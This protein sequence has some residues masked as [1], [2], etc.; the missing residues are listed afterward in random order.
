[1]FKSA[2]FYDF[3][4]AA[5]MSN[6]TFVLEDPAESDSRPRKRQVQERAPPRLTPTLYKASVKTLANTAAIRIS[7]SISNIDDAILQRIKKCLQRANHNNT[8]EPEAKAAFYLAS[9]LM[10]QYN[11]SQAEVLAHEP[12]ATQQQYA[13]Q[14]VV[15]I[16]RAD[17]S[18]NAVNNQAFVDALASAMNAFFDCKAYS[19]REVY[20]MQW[21]FYG[22]AE[23]TIAAAMVFEMAYNLIG[24]WA[25]PYKG[26]A[27]K[28]SYCI[29]V[30]QELDRMARDEKLAQEKQALEAEGESLAMQVEK[31]EA[32]RRAE[33]DRLAVFP[34]GLEEPVESNTD[35]LLETWS[36]D[37][38]DTSGDENEPDFAE[39]DGVQVDPQADLD[40]EIKRLIK[41]EPGDILSSFG[42]VSSPPLP[43]T[44]ANNA[45]AISNRD[46]LSTSPGNIKQE[47]DEQPDGKTNW[48]SSMQ[49]T[50]FRVNASR[51]AD[52]YLKDSGV[53]LSCSTSR[54]AGV[55]DYSAYLQGTR[56]SKKIDIR[57]KRIEE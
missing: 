1:M 15:S 50:A 13:G 56:D 39:E 17:G 54:S 21:T 32:Q 27:S 6:F 28:N 34:S 31:E 53:K 2:L 40:V 52:D 10:G 8:P 47:E 18:M 41:P 30:A 22:I 4:I 23:N 11:V 24:E 19:S 14:S 33:L 9:R 44:P 12:P 35:E 45:K 5:I 29:G 46:A 25:R 7:S 26:N 49:L 57:G 16:K 38:E 55:S 48:A 42:Q 37:Y 3:Q 36:D 20:S 51:I 43:T